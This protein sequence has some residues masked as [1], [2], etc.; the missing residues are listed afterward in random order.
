MIFEFHDCSKVVMYVTSMHGDFR[1][2]YICQV[3]Y[4]LCYREGVLT[5]HH[6]IVNMLYHC[7]LIAPFFRFICHAR[8]VWIDHKPVCLD[9]ASELPIEHHS[10]AK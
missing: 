1:S 9:L 5:G 4:K 10:A 3:A 7:D 8:V 6:Q 2:A